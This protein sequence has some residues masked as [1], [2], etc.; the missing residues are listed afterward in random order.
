MTKSMIQVAFESTSEG[1]GFSEVLGPKC[2]RSMHPVLVWLAGLGAS[3][4]PSM[5]AALRRALMAFSPAVARDPFGFDWAGFNHAGMLRAK[6]WLEGKGSPAS[7]NLSLTA[8]RGCARASWQLR[9]ISVDELERIRSVQN[10]KHAGETE[11]GRWV[12]RA[13]RA[14]LFRLESVHP[15]I[16]AR[17]RAL[18]GLLLGGGLRRAESVSLKRTDVHLSDALILVVGKGGRVRRVPMSGPVAVAVAGWL[19]LLPSAYQHIFPQVSRSGRFLQDRAITGGAVAEL[20]RRRTAR[21]G[22]APVR[23]HDLRRSCASDC[24]EAGIDVLAVQELLGHAN[25]ATTLK[26]DLRGVKARRAAVEAVY[27][28]VD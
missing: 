28:P 10:Y 26:Y 6:V 13:D 22:I 9:L 5:L 15:V 11:K 21:A 27:V 12:P 1:R 17:D 7:R 3:S 25:P 16:A 20:L 24:L 19:A 8:L 2:D 4:R 14:R 23:P 18:L